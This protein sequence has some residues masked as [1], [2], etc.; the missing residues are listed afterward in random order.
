MIC[1]DNIKRKD[2]SIDLSDLINKLGVISLLVEQV[3]QGDIYIPNYQYKGSYS[4]EKEDNNNTPI[5]GA[6]SFMDE[7]I[8]DLKVIENA[9]Y[10]A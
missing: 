4:E 9:L 8:K 10:P 7:V 2:F 6:I 3:A 1:K 5:W